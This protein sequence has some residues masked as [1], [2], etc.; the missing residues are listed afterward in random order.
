VPQARRTV[1]VFFHCLDGPAPDLEQLLR[2]EVRLTHVQQLYA[3]SLLAGEA[4]PISEDDLRFALS[5]PSS[6]WVDVAAD[7][8]TRVRELAEKG[9]LVT[10]EDDAELARLRALDER[11]AGA[12][13]NLYG[14]FHYLMTKWSG[15]DLRIA[16]DEGEFPAVTEEMIE[17]FVVER[18]EPP[19]PFHSLADP[20]VVHELPVVRRQGGLYDALARRKT[21]RGFDRTVRMSVE[22]LSLVLHQVWGC[23]GTAPIIGDLYCIKRTSPSG[24]GLH[25]VEAY[26]IVSGVEGVETGIYHY[27]VRSHSL[28]LMERLGEEE[29]MGLAADFTCGQNYFGTAHVSTVMTARF[30]RTHWKYPKQQKAYPVILMDAAHLSQTHYL[31]AAEL[32]LGAYVTVAINARE[33]EDRLGLDGVTEGVVAMVGCGKQRPQGSPFE[34]RF[35]PYAPSRAA[36]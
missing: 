27:D 11:I 15:V 17:Q 3:V 34:P 29:A 20:L 33:I 9:V 21:T 24:G 22:E 36:E 13:W 16:P 14:A 35:T 19:D 2:G 30:P 4:F 32:G 18:G 6:D 26:P 10:D 1:Y 25:P 28:E 7:D 12:D 23:Q 5:I 8:G 31:V